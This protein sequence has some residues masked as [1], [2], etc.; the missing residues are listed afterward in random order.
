MIGNCLASTSDS[1]KNPEFLL[2]SIDL[3][4]IDWQVLR[5]GRERYPL[6]FSKTRIEKRTFYN[7]HRP[8]EVS[9]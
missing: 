5:L 4:S 3:E 7:I 9:F 8:T 6:Q 2:V 1:L